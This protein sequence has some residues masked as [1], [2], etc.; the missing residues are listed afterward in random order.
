MR[1]DVLTLFPEMF[2]AVKTSIVGRAM[3]N[4]LIELNLINFREFSTDKQKHVDDCPYGGGAGM[5]IKPEPVYDAYQ[6]IVKDL[7][8]K[9]K[10]IYM[11]PQGKV[12][13]QQIARDLSKEN[14]LIL[15]CGHYEGID[16][17]IKRSRDD[18]KESI[19][20]HAYAREGVYCSRIRPAQ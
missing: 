5:V 7:E 19:P 12:L 3:N 9:P 18:N 17:R 1:F 2:D 8:Y 20:S 11:S 10:V 4:N 13:T 16:Q 15:L 6:S 14:H